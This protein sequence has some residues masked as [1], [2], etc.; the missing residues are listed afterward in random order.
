MGTILLL[1]VFLLHALSLSLSV[2]S[3]LWQ[4]AVNDVFISHHPLAAS[5]ANQAMCANFLTMPIQSQ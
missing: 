5:R 2:S 3:P 4:F 1:T